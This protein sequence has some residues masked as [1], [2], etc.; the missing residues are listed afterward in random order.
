MKIY[1]FMYFHVIFFFFL[2]GFQ[3]MTCVYKT[4]M[5]L[6]LYC[7]YFPCCVC[8]F[9]LFNIVFCHFFLIKDNNWCS[10]TKTGF[11][12]T[13]RVTVWLVLFMMC[14]TFSAGDRSGLEA[15]QLGMKPHLYCVQTQLCLQPEKITTEVWRKEGWWHLSPQ[16]SN[17]CF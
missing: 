14:Q 15:G 16:N 12:I 3:R 1:I 6:C 17:V 7:N 8:L 9:F 2:C 5:S 13:Y 10:F 11:S 4:C